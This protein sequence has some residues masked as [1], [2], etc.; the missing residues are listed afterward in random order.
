M[1]RLISKAQAE[2]SVKKSRFISIAYPVNTLEEVKEKVV[3][4]RKLYSDATHVV[5]AAVVGK[6]GTLFSSSD[7]REPKNTAGR[8]ALEVLRGSGITN[9]CVC[10][11]RYFGGTLL[12]TGGLVKA[13]GE[14]VKEVLKIVETEENIDYI[15]FTL[16]LDYDLYTPIRNLMEKQGAKNISEEFTTAI[17]ITCDIPLINRI[18][19]EKEVM[20]WGQG[21]IRIKKDEASSVD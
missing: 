11:I 8:P 1:K 3:L 13:Y 14:S 17:L 4:T 20:D 2:I 10:I 5:H 6:S 12:G 18:S 9:I 19:F 7:D 15:H 21:R 16:S